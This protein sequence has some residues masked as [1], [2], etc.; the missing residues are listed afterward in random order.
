MNPLRATGLPGLRA[1]DRYPWTGRSALRGTAA[2]P[3]QTTRDLRTQCGARV[4]RARRAYRVFAAAGVPLVNGPPLAV[5]GGSPTALQRGSRVVPVARVREG[6]ASLA[7]A[8]EGYAGRAVAD[9]LGVG[10]PSVYK[11]AHRGRAMSRQ[12]ERLVRQK[13]E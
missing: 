3:W 11:A 9:L 12:W 8:G 7:I 10:T 4:A 13:S 1:L 6:V 5:T 2:R